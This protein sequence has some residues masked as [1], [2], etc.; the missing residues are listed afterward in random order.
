ML[1]VVEMQCPPTRNEGSFHKLI[2]V[3]NLAPIGPGVNPMMLFPLDLFST[4]HVLCSGVPSTL[5]K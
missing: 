1:L 3:Q 2:N 5:V 4:F